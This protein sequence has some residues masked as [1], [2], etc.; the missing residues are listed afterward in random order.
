MSS[1]L[2]RFGP[3]ATLT[4]DPAVYF[5]AALQKYLMGYPQNYTFVLLYLSMYFLSMI[6]FIYIY[7][8]AARKLQRWES[9]TSQRTR[10]LCSCDHSETSLAPLIVYSFHGL[11]GGRKHKRGFRG[12]PSKPETALLRDAHKAEQL[13]EYKHQT[14]TRS[15]P[16]K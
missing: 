10:M 6:R 7:P 9:A 11:E 3:S 1:R 5:C 4:T 13:A 12:N 14:Y 8:G 2:E 15:Q 16:K